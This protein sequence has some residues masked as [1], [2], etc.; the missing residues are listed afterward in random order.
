MNEGQFLT[1]ERLKWGYDCLLFR[2][3]VSIK[4]TDV[5]FGQDGKA[6]GK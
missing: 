5:R 3:V 4:R 1:E 6:R 2:R